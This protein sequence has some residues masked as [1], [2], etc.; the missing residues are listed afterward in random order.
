MLEFAMHTEIVRPFVL[1]GANPFGLDMLERQ[2]RA[3]ETIA[4]QIRALKNPEPL[5]DRQSQYALAKRR[6]LEEPV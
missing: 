3:L 4:E 6:L 5:L 2:A 1:A